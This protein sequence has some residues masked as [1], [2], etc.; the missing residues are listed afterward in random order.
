MPRHRL[1]SYRDFAV[2]WGTLALLFALAGC[3]SGEKSEG[4]AEV[5]TAPE[6]RIYRSGVV[7]HVGPASEGCEPRNQ[8]ITHLVLHHTGASLPSSLK[9]L[10]GKEE[11]RPVGVHYVVSDEPSPRV[12]DMVPE[13]FAAYHAGRSA[14]GRAEGLNHTSIGIEIV[15]LD[16]NRHPYPAEQVELIL[17]LCDEIV[18]RHGILPMNVVAHSDVAVGRKIDPGALFPW[19]HL[20]E[21]GIGAW[22]LAVDVEEF[23]AA[24]EPDETLSRALLTAYGY[25]LDAGREGLRLGVE[26]FQRHFRPHR[27]DGTMDA[28]TGALLRALLR[29][30]RPEVPLGLPAAVSAGG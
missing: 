18:R 26:A 14:W 8:I 4:A 16:G 5:E 11:G 3:A 23:L 15:N 10:E 24:P 6:V 25:R 21:H 22:P 12:I 9:T 17:A 27:V 29:R 2:S 1:R 30:Y 13:S 28:E 20:A 7:H 19:R